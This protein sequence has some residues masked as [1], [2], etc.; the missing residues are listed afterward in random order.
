MLS[1]YLFE[2]LFHIADAS[3]K[4]PFP[5]PTTYRIALSHYLDITSVPTTQILKE[6]AQYVKDDAEKAKLI[7][8]G[9]PTEEGKVWFLLENKLIFKKI[10][11]KFS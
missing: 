11:Y 10:S 9:S 4:H 7:L 6:F 1:K 3:K 5:C 2:I 8:M